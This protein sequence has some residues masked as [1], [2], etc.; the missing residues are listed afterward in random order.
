MDDTHKHAIY[1]PRWFIASCLVHIAPLL[2]Y[3]PSL[4]SQHLTGVYLSRHVRLLKAL[5]VWKRTVLFV[6]SSLVSVC[7]CASRRCLCL[8]VSDMMFDMT[9]GD[10][11]SVLFILLPSWQLELRS[12]LLWWQRWLTSA[13]SLEEI[14]EKHFLLLSELF[15]SHLWDFR[16]SIFFFYI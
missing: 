15:P 9:R 10:L 4:K 12:L 1:A 7:V 14:C 11:P 16:D 3:L 6:N 5:L 8:C 2:I 13:V